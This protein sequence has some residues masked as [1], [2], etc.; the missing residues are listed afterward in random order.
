MASRTLRDTGTPADGRVV[1]IGASYFTAADPD[2]VAVV[3]DLVDRGVV[4]PWTD[5][6]HV[7]G[8]SGI[9]GVRSGRSGTRR[10]PGCAASSRRWPRSRAGL[11][12]RQSHEVGAV[13][14]GR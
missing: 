4:R 5:A 6:F 3:D 11:A 2:F 8:P 1:D 14:R 12:V 7:A 9:E 13:T 10:R